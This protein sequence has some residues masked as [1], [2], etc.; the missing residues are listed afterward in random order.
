MMPGMDGIELCAKIKGTFEYCHIPVILLTAKNTDDSRIEGYDSGADGYVT[1]PFNFKLLHAQIVNQLRKQERKGSHFRNQLVFEIEALEYTSMDE[2]F[3]RR[4]MACVNAHIDDGEFSQ[5]DFTRE[6]N[7]SRTVLTEKLKSL[8]GL[9]PTAFMVDIRLRAA[10]RLLEQQRHMRIAD[11]AYAVGFNDPKYFSTCFRKSSA[12]VPRNSSNN[13]MARVKNRITRI[14]S[15]GVC[16][17]C[18][19]ALYCLRCVGRLLQPADLRQSRFTVK[20]QP[21]S[22]RG[23]VFSYPAKALR[24][25]L[26]EPKTNLKTMP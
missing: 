6:M 8:T 14:F 9:T 18:C 11:L 13:S 17:M 21:R 22:R 26:S 25:G 15:G 16:V 4:A 12:S 20:F 5:A 10:Y 3:M 7:T 1:K 2:D 24:T 19:Y 23:R